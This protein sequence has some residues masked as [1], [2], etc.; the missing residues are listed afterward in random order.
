MACCLCEVQQNT[1]DC[2]APLHAL[3][4]AARQPCNAPRMRA[5]SKRSSMPTAATRRM[6]RSRI[7]SPASMARQAGRRTWP[8]TCSCLPTP[9][10]VR[11]CLATV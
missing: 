2:G 8:A 11:G 9:G 6:R 7:A 3:V 10:P 5:R 1:S 4:A